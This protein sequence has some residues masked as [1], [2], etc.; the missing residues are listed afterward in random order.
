MILNRVGAKNK[1][2]CHGML[3]AI[4]AKYF[5]IWIGIEF[6][7]KIILILFTNFLWKYVNFKEHKNE[8][9]FLIYIVI[10]I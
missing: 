4:Y 2:F 9:M 7:Y 10:N 3:T 1:V 6:V 8:N 5:S